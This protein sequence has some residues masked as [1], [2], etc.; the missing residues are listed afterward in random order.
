MSDDTFDVTILGGGPTGLFGV[1]YAGMRQ[2]RTL[3]LDALEELGGQLT[4][5]Y[6]EKYVYDVGGFPRIL[7]R[8]LAEGLIDQAMQF[9]PEV[10]LDETAIDLEPAETDAD[11]GVRV[12]R[13]RTDKAERLSRTVVISAGIGAFEPRRL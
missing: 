9:H 1:F 6:P 11:G 4:A 8:E 7:A 5:L 10:G 12:W 13:L 2:M 3:V